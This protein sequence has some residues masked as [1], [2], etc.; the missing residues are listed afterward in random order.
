MVRYHIAPLERDEVKDYINHRL[1][2]VGP[3]HKIKFTDEALQAIAGFS[4][5]T[6][7][8]INIICDR[9]LL[10][11]FVTETYIIDLDIINRCLEELGHYF[12]VKR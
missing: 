6:P 7:R 1:K 10:A 3:E 9:A 4:Y 11:G 2:T 5:S 12:A 8:L